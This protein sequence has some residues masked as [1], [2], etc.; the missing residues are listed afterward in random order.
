M[1]GGL[2]QL[3]A[4]GVEDLYITENPQISYFKII[5]RRHTNFTKE[6]VPHL[7]QRV[8]PTFGEH[9][10]TNIAIGG[11]LIGQIYI[12]VTLPRVRAFIDPRVRFAWVKRVG[13]KL[14]KSVE[15]EINN[16][17]IDKHYGEWLCLWTELTGGFVGDKGRSMSK[18]IGDI[19]EL[20]SFT[21]EKDEYTLFIP[22]YFWFCRDTANALPAVSLL[23]GSLKINVEFEELEKCCYYGPTHYIRCRED[24][25]GFLPYE[26]LEQ[27]VDGIPRAGIFI[28]Y[29][30][31]TKRLYYYKLSEEK[32]VGISV[33][34]DFDISEE[35]EPEIN[36]ILSRPSNLQYLI[37]GNTSMYSLY[38]ELN[39]TSFK[40]TL[41]PLNTRN[42]NF[43][44]CFLLI[45]Y[46]Y[47]DDEERFKLL[48]TKHEY[49]IEQIQY[50][51]DIV[52]DGV[53]YNAQILANNP[54]KAMVWVVQLENNRIGNDAFNYTDSQARS[55]YSFEY[56]NRMN[57][58]KYVKQNDTII[59]GEP[60]GE[61]L[62]T[63]ETILFN[64]NPLLSMRS[65]EYFDTIQPNQFFGTSV[66]TGINVYSFAL[67]PLSDQPSGTCNTSEIVNIEVS[68]NLSNKV[69]VKNRVLFRCYCICTNI[70]RVVGGTGGVLFDL[71]KQ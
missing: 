36:N 48:R 45:D 17:S 60:E 58:G 42:L 49:L 50:T 16:K 63:E 10:S 44:N 30:V 31:V 15:I 11:D 5:Y 2:I 66:S 59:I 9:I 13:F 25:V 35:N 43:T 46:Y 8:T 40:Y 68:M 37:T 33:D 21:R 61:S 70:F 18:M 62:I 6:Q 28:D 51:P 39:A 38:P 26:Y 24:M 34:E 4:R 1:S 56:E 69:T 53:Q 32:F 3:V 29:D 52:I 12:V 22:L 71:Q 54:C 64:G 20:T 27:V 41:V 14:I 23:H 65:H 57:R 7:F 47:L 19:P 67:H 55:Y